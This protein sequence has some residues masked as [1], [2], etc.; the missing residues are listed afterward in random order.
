M[1]KI[2]TLIIILFSASNLFAATKY[3]VGTIGNYSS[4]TNWNTM[5]DGSGTSGA[6]VNTDDIVIDRNA[7]ITIDGTY[8]PSSVWVINN[9]IVNFINTSTAKTYTIGGGS[10][11]PSFKIEGGAILNVTGTGSITLEMFSGNAEIYGILDFTGNNSKMNYNVLATTTRIKTGGKIRYGALSS[12]GVGTTTSFFMES[13]STYEVYKDAGTFPTGTFDANSLL[14][15]TGAVAN[16]A[17]FSMNS[18]AGSYGNYEFNSPGYTGTSLGVNQNTTFNNFTLT[19]D[20]S[21]KWI[22]STS[23]SSIYT[24]TV[25]GNLSIS[26]GSTFVINNATSGNVLTTLLVKGNINNNGLITEAIGNVGSVIEIGRNTSS[27]F[28]S[29][30]NGITN[31]VNMKMNKS[32]GILT[33]LTD[34]NLPNSPNAQLTLT[35]GNIDVLTNNKILFIQNPAAT[36]LITGSAASHIIG[37]LKRSSNQLSGYI[38]P[39]SNDGIQIAK[40]TI[41][42]NN[43]NATDWTVEFI[44]TNPNAN[45]GLTP[46][47]IDIVSNYYWNISRTGT[48]PAD[49][50][51]LTLYYSGLTT[52]SVLIPSQVKIVHWNGTTWDNLGGV[53]GGGSVDNTLGST[54]GTAPADP[55]TTFSPFAIAGILGTLPIS[56]EYFNGTKNITSNKLSWK[57][58]CS[59]NSNVRVTLEHSTT[60]NNFQPIYSLNANALQCLQPFDRTDFNPSA[61]INYYRLKVTDENGKINY[62]KIIGLLNKESGVELLGILPNPVSNNETTILSLS[63][64]KKTVFHFVITDM[65]G[66]QIYKDFK[67]LVAG[68]NQ[69]TLNL[70][71]LS[72]G[73]YVLAGVTD[74]GLKVSLQFIKN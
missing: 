34:I 27:T 59:G 10:V 53:D 42:T 15:N 11:S 7:S 73:S 74:E 12:N 39:V 55:I 50:G 60:N 69:L 3:W 6:P 25:N 54:G 45:A 28:S 30:A 8:F 2:Y 26:G 14:L 70:P 58:N 9:A 17:S 32:A 63:A 68:N 33:A 23:P 37:K 29:V 62:S 52:S 49:A 21:G 35:N 66:K 71:V 57:I 16:A 56:I 72:S 44:P 4:G 22:F 40:A 48:T 61:G 41:T 46:A 64:A 67:T 43:N 38:F 24:L 31:D 18:A 1:K 51:F 19:N 20:G 65:N 13:G 47:V 36:A 5:P